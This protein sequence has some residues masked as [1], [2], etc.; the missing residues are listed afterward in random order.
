[1]FTVYRIFKTKKSNN[2]K[3]NRKNAKKHI[4]GIKLT[5]YS[6]SCESQ[7]CEYKRKEEHN[8]YGKIEG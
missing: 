3:E 2:S 4:D 1:V 5:W 7:K 8:E 6:L